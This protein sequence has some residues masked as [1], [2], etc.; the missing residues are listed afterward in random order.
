MLILTAGLALGV[1]WSSIKAWQYEQ[2]DILLTKASALN[3]VQASS[4]LYQYIAVLG[5][6]DP[7]ATERVAS[8]YWSMGEYV[9][10]LS[11]YQNSWIELNNIY[12]GNAWLRASNPGLAK[13]SFDKANQEAETAESQ[14][15]LATV[16]FIEGR[17]DHGCNHADRAKKLNLNSPVATNLEEI[18]TI[19]QGTSVLS[20]R[21]KATKLI[22]ALI[23]DIGLN[24]LES[25]STKSSADWQLIAKV[26]ASRGEYEEAAAAIQSGLKQDP[27]NQSLLSFMIYL[28]DIGGNSAKNT[29]Y[30]AR[31]EDTKFH[32]FSK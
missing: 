11:V 12:L 22:N 8:Q 28:N 31:L 5:V 14:S 19:L 7:L 16:A 24:K 15:G 4:Q 6:D 10:S 17:V 18:C 13:Y 2:V 27:S 23:F 26:Y 25:I 1:S 29:I 32:N 20:E 30:R 3:D 9:R 21:A